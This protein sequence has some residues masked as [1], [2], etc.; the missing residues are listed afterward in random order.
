MTER[1][2]WK[3]EIIEV[4]NELGGYGHYDDIFEIIKDRNRVSGL[5]KSAWK[6][7]IRKIIE[8]NSSDSDNFKGKDI[9]YSVYGKGKGYWGLR[10][11]KLNNDETDVTYDDVCYKEG[12]IVLKQHICRERNPQVIKKAKELFLKNHNNTLF[13]EA[14]G[15]RFTDKYNIDDE[16]IEGHH[17]IPINELPEDSETR[18]E[19]IIMLCSNCHRIIHKIRPW[20]KKNELNNLFKK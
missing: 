7:T 9:F 4:L 5:N 17:I 18:P 3:D 8:D 16:F 19:D 10:N 2:T 14:C 12:K 11:Y 15:F 13:C 1:V 6:N 20:I